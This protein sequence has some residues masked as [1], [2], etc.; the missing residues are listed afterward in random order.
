[1]SI[2]PAESLFPPHAPSATTPGSAKPPEIDLTTATPRTAVLIVTWNRK[3]AADAVLAALAAQ[4]VDR[5]QLH[6]VIID[7]GST[8]GTAHFLAQRWAPTA[9]VDNPTAKAHEPAFAFAATSTAPCKGDFGSLTL[10]RNT[11]NHGGCGGFNTGFAFADAHLDTPAQPLE[12]CWLVD[13]DVDLPTNALPQLL[14]TAASDPTIGLIGSR[15]VDFHNR[16]TTIETTIYFDPSQGWM[17]P[18]PAPN[19]RLA[20]SHAQWVQTS[21]GTRGTGP[22]TGVRDVDV[23]S[24]CS[25]LARWSAVE[26]VGYW[27]SRYFIYCD[28][29]DWCLRFGRSGYRVVCDLD[30]VVYHT[31][32]LSKLT[33]ARGYYASRNL[34]WLLQKSFAGDA[35]RR[36]TFRRL[37]SQLVHARKAASHCR[38]FHAEI[39]RRTAHD[40]ATNRGGKLDFEGPKPA[41]LLEALDAHKLLRPGSH[42][43]VMCSHPES[44]AWAE[45]FRHRLSYAL[46]DADRLADVPRFTHV[47]RD[48]VPPI[49]P[50][51]GVHAATPRRV[52]FKPRFRSKLRVQAWLLRDPP[53]AVVVFDQHNECPLLWS[54][55]NIHIDRRTPTQAQVEHDGWLE[56][57]HFALRWT[58]T[59]LRCL[60]H[61]AT[62]KP[63]QRTGPYG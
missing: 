35:L 46:R 19:H 58:W 27:D 51:H 7:N 14:R 56:R 1:M 23:V 24:A 15:T 54:R 31:Y 28:D 5:G 29:A 22:F 32:W 45:E 49:A 4:Q 55:R 40:A 36:V 2:I 30:A 16:D 39:F 61:S 18:D 43:A 11:T 41:A 63:Y 25:L 17:G 3:A 50:L 12:F 20:E 47:C 48:H 26:K 38:L 42:L 60:W 8:D 13:D 62:V 33:P 34:I 9:I 53:D 21:G 57:S 52:E 59:L 10:I 37:M 6:I 44:I